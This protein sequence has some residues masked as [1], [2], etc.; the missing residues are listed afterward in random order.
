MLIPFGV[1]SAAGASGGG[2]GAAAYE[3]ISTTLVT[4]AVSPVVF[5][6]IDQTYKHLQIRY[7]A[8]GT[9]SASNTQLVYSVMSRF[10]YLRGDGST[11]TSSAGISPLQLAD[12][13]GNTLGSGIFSSGVI[14]FLDYANTTTNKTVRSL[15]G[16]T[17]LNR[18]QLSSGLIVSTAAISS[19][20]LSTASGQ[21]AIGSR[22]SLY[23]IKG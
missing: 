1:F 18:I 19:I 6:S 13:A 9:V 17:G 4:T 21:F 15:S 14:D 12:I 10:H 5:S 23:G 7:T 8:R 20:S 2:G 3:L 11:V 22:F 16:S